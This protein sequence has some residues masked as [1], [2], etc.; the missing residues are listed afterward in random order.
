MSKRASGHSV[1]F[2][3][4]KQ[5]PPKT[6]CSHY[7]LWLYNECL[8]SEMNTGGTILIPKV[9]DASALEHQIISICS[10]VTRLFHK[11]LASRLDMAVHF[12][13]S[14]NGFK[15]VR[16]VVANLFILRNILDHAK[17]SRK[18]LAICFLALQKAFDFVAH[19]SLIRAMRAK[20]IRSKLVSYVKN[21]YK[22]AKTR[23]EFGQQKK[24]PSYGRGKAKRPTLIDS[25]QY[26][27]CVS[28][29]SRT[30]SVLRPVI[31]Y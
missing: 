12:S 11:I 23:I 31:G 14:K 1:K 29:T 5:L 19:D 15:R 30:R 9:D 26:A 27:I 20:K 17:K 22:E 8:P 7:N 2:L 24:S 6:L 21:V 28:R 4:V 25:I 3:A 16:G 10:H 18:S 13:P